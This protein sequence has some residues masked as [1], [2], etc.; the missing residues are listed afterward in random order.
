MKNYFLFA[1]LLISGFFAC[2]K[3][4]VEVNIT[5]A[6][7]LPIGDRVKFLEAG[8]S[9]NEEIGVQVFSSD[10]IPVENVT[11]FFNKEKGDAILS[12]SIVVTDQEGMA[13][14]QVGLGTNITQVVIHAVAFQIKGSPITFYFDQSSAAP[15][16]ISI[17]SGN[18]QEGTFYDDIDSALVV[19]VTDKFGNP[20]SQVDVEFEIISGDGSLV[21]P[22]DRTNPEG[23]AGVDFNPGPDSTTNEVKASIAN[24][25]F[26]TFTVYNLVPSLLEEPVNEGDHVDLEWSASDSPIFSGYYINRRKRGTYTYERINTIHHVDSTTFSD[27]DIVPGRQYQYMIETASSRDNLVSS[28]LENIEVGKFF[29]LRAASR[30][31]DWLMDEGKDIL[32][33]VAGS[34]NRI[35]YFSM[36]SRELV[37]S[38]ELAFQ[39]GSI[40][41]TSDKSKMYISQPKIGTIV[42]YD[43]DTKSL[44][45][46]IDATDSM[47]TSSISDIYVD[48]NGDLFATGVGGY[49]VKMDPT[50]GYIPRRI[51]S[52]LK[53]FS[54]SVKFMADDGEYLFASEIR[55]SPNSLYKFD[56]KDPAVPLVKED[57]HG[58]VYNTNGVFLHPIKSEIILASGK[59][60]D[61]N[62]FLQ[63]GIMGGGYSYG[64]LSKDGS[65]FYG[66]SNTNGA[67]YDTYVNVY[68]TQTELIIDRIQYAC[69]EEGFILLPDES[70]IIIYTDVLGVNDYPKRLL[71]IDI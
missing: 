19:F 44:E 11:I 45:I 40:A 52:G 57:E 43:L 66:V 12:D 67:P 46:S 65:R 1:S 35:Y 55:L 16:H 69:E 31:N 68:D 13:T 23:R 26:V 63:V 70:A 59:I 6:Y 21:R 50:E 2:E 71:F 54:S 32:Y 24:G 7:L 53:F 22:T 64:A 37:D 39:P 10:S 61:K 56:L 41:L 14:I 49:I 38:L 17:F 30:A 28:N 48:K 20:V 5:P 36:E 58:S 47:G 33:V 42:L 34:L 51:G 15:E 60:L 62:T 9:Q 8:Q 29:K 25:S 3:P 4:E 27:F 18:A